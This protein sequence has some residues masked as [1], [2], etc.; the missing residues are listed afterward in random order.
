MAMWVYKF[1]L[2]NLLPTEPRFAVRISLIMILLFSTDLF[3][4]LK[5]KSKRMAIKCQLCDPLQLLSLDL[6]EKVMKHLSF[7]NLT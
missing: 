2:N 5:H 3:Q 4:L 1:G 6:I 7:A